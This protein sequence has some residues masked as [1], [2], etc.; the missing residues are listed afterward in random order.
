MVAAGAV[1]V[2]GATD[3]EH[4]TIPPEVQAAIEALLSSPSISPEAR[5]QLAQ[6]FDAFARL[7]LGDPEWFAKAVEQLGGGSAPPSALIA[8]L[9]LVL[10]RVSNESPDALADALARAQA[11]GLSPPP[12]PAL[13]ETARQVVEKVS[14]GEAARVLGAQR[15]PQTRV[16]QECGREFQALHKAIYCGNTCRQRAFQRKRRAERGLQE[17]PQAEREVVSA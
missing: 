8:A 9:S 13:A 6:F 7:I 4:G 2:Q 10:S 14:V 16:C 12:P 3:I 15:I 17:V 11:E 1:T 5:A